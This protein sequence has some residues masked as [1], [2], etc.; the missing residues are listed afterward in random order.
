[1]CKTWWKSS[2]EYTNVCLCG[3]VHHSVDFFVIHDVVDEVCRAEISL[4]KLVVGVVPNNRLNIFNAGAIIQFVEVDNFVVRIILHQPNHYMRCT[5]GDMGRE[6]GICSMGVSPKTPQG[7]VRQHNTRQDNIRQRQHKTRKRQNN[8][9]G[10]DRT[11]RGNI[12]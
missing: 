7:N 12:L 8:R 5:E 4:D 1:M 3:E 9:T 2:E 10:Q 6:G 11:G